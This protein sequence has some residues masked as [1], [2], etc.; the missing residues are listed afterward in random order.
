V[1]ESYRTSFA[2]THW[3]VVLQA[4]QGD[5]PAAEAALERLCQ[6]YW[7]P[8]YAYVRRL[9]RSETDAQDLTQQF[10]A[11]FLE[12]NYFR[13][14]DRQR[15]KF[16]SF[17][18]TCLKHFLAHEKQKAQAAKRGGT[19][20]FIAWDDL[21]K[22]EIFDLAESPE[23]S[24]E[25]IYERQWAVRVMD[26]ALSKLRDEFAATGKNRDFEHFREYLTHDPPDGA[27][28]KVAELI[29]MNANA[30]A[31]AVH[32]FRQRYR[33][34][35]RKEIAHTVADPADIEDELRHLLGLLVN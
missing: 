6:V 12:R 18:L 26:Q 15:G 5:S 2:T 20:T 10:F 30:V 17:L 16:R 33:D 28:P 19:I 1:K 4:G 34:L 32:R 24:P 27:Y 7:P 31:V 11:H 9:G 23:K 14:A 29:G 3:S 25:Q 8:L 13:V 35:V 22:E 21:T